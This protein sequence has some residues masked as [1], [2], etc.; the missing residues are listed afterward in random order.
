TYNQGGTF[1]VTLTACEY[2]SYDTC[3]SVQS[4]TITIYPLPVALFIPPPTQVLI[5]NQACFNNKSLNYVQLEWDFGNGKTSNLTD[6]VVCTSYSQE[7]T[8][9]V[10]LIATSSGGCKD[11]FRLISAVT[12]IKGTKLLIPNAFTGLASGSSN[13]EE[14]VDPTLTN[15]STA[16]NQVFY[17]YIVGILKSYEMRIFNKWGELIFESHEETDCPPADPDGL[18]NWKGWN[19]FYRGKMA[20]QD[21]YVFTIDVVFCSGDELSKTGYVMLLR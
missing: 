16:E 9:D 19:G 14:N 11:T 2:T 15:I 17:P 12:V 8:Y 3:I 18:K 5:G 1:T 6:P 10:E 21:V 13:G 7:G 20:K 4:A